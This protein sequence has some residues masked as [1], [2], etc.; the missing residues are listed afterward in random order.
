MSLPY[1][2]I[3][4]II[5]AGLLYLAGVFI[6]VKKKDY[7]LPSKIILSLG[8]WFVPTIFLGWIGFVILEVVRQKYPDSGL[9]AYVIFIT[10]LIGA[11]TA[12]AKLS[13]KLFAQIIPFHYDTNSLL[14][15]YSQGISKVTSTE[16]LAQHSIG[17]ICETMGIPHGFLFD[18]YADPEDEKTYRLTGIG[19]IGKEKP[20][21]LTLTS[22]NPLLLNLKKGLPCIQR[23]ELSSTGDFSFLPYTEQVWFQIL[24]AEIYI[25]IYSQDDWI[26]LLALG[27]KTDA[28]SYSEEELTLITT[29]ADQLSLA[30]KNARLVDSLMRVNNDFRRAYKA[31]EQSNRQ[32]QQAISHLQKIDQTKS[33]FISIAS[34][35][36]RTPLTVMRGYAEILLEEPAIAANSYHGKMLK[37]I[38][39]GILRLNE[40]IDSMLD[41]AS[42]DARALSL[43]K[44]KISLQY[45][46]QSLTKPL[47]PTLEQRKI[48]LTVEGLSDLPLIQADQEAIRKVFNNL[49]LN[50]FQSTPNKGKIYISGLHVSPGQAGL[51]YGG[52]EIIVSDTGIG[53]KR[54]NLD[55][56][57]T[58]FYQ[59]SDLL[60]HSTG[61]TKFKGSGTGLGLAIAKGIVEAHG[62]KIWAES[63]GY[64]EEKCPGS[65]FHVLLPE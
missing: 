6:I 2:L 55:L 48:E 16:Q 65:Q 58:K 26:G 34:H 12:I 20:N 32:L 27:R 62:G 31:M 30:L 19:N 44:E 54:E 23:K 8:I 39:S 18:V 64:D 15:D 56:I 5:L 7:Q 41:M 17:L 1:F 40:I 24:D 25:P 46:I 10:V 22:K 14:R 29:L 37:G 52:V 28:R 33:D 53:I 61:Q 59:S 50:A 60:H 36:L 51:V 45:I 57:F 21:D 38:H 47:Q 43:H 49:I 9:G 63:P 42:I 3:I 35:E 13:P 4:L 11:W